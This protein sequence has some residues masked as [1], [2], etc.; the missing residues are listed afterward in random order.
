[1]TPRDAEYFLAAVADR[2][3]SPLFTVDD[4][5]VVLSDRFPPLS[6]GR[7]PSPHFFVAPGRLDDESIVDMAAT[8]RLCDEF[9]WPRDY[10]ISQSPHLVKDG[11][12]VLSGGAL[13]MLLLQAPRQKLA[14]K[15]TIAEVRSRVGVEAKANAKQLGKLLDNMR[16]CHTASAPHNRSEHKKCLAIAELRP[17]LFLGVAAPETWRLFSVVERDGRAALGDELPDLDRLHFKR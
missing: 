11:R 17:P 12:V 3:E 7:P 6:D 10:L 9:G 2:P 13:D 4:D 8:A 15:M 14:A 5:R 1:V 16:A